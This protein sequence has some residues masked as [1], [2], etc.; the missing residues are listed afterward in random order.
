HAME[1]ARYMRNQLLRDADW[2]SMAHSVE[3]RVPLVD[4]TLRAR[5]AGLGFEPARSAAK[6]ALAAAAA[7]EL[8]AALFAGR[9]G[10]CCMPVMEWLEPDAGGRRVR[11]VRSIRS[12]RSHGDLSRRL[13]RR[14]LESFFGEAGF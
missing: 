13:A 14:L 7:P 4:A 3:L 1:T 10:G 8:P 5:L 12:V 6:A 9:R 11:G 2:G